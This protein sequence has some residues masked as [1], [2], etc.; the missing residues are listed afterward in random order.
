LFGRVGYPIKYLK[1]IELYDKL[2][3]EVTIIILLDRVKMLVGPFED[4]H[5]NT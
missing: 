1:F 3:G 5:T 2:C 4:F